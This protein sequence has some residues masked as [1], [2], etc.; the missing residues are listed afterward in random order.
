[1]PLNTTAAASRTNGVGKLDQR[2]AGITAATFRVLPP[3]RTYYPIF[4]DH[5]SHLARTSGAQQRRRSSIRPSMSSPFG[6]G[7]GTA[8]LSLCSHRI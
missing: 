7:V 3:Q 5:D 4:T 8:P 2:F 6:R 1:M